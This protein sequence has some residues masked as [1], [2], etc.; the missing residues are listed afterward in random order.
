MLF[1]TQ[2]GAKLQAASVCSAILT[3]LLPSIISSAALAQSATQNQTVPG[4][5][6]PYQP[7]SQQPVQLQPALIPAGVPPADTAGRGPNAQSAQGPQFGQGIIATTTQQIEGYHIRRYLGVVRGVKV[8]QPTIGES[9]RAG[10][11]GI[12]GG[13]IGA[14]TEM[15]E[16]TRQQAYDQLLE[17]STALGANAVLGLHFDSSS[18][19]LGTSEMG[20]EVICYGTA[21]YIEADR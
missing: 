6:P 11:K 7:Y 21:V 16:K 3:T 4:Q 10:F 15:C 14:Y 8:F 13:N 18:F 9:I 12:I 2:R 17:R 19:S 1:T 20:T 5:S